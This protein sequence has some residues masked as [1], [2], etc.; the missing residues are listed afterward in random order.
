[1]SACE[2]LSRAKGETAGGSALA[3]VYSQFYDSGH[4]WL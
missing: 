4:D 2:R 3:R 1:M